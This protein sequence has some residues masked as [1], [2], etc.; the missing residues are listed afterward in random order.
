[1]EKTFVLM[2]ML[3]FLTENQ[4]LEWQ[5]LSE[6]DGIFS[7]FCGPE[8]RYISHFKLLDSKREGIE[9]AEYMKRMRNSKANAFDSSKTTLLKMCTLQREKHHL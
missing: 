7:Q 3:S 8:R 1:M 5:D 6:E 2:T 4:A 9:N